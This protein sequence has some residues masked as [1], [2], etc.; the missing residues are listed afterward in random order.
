MA[1]LF[2]QSVGWNTQLTPQPAYSEFEQRS[3]RL[4]LAV[5]RM[6]PAR[7]PKSPPHASWRH[8]QPDDY[9]PSIKVIRNERIAAGPELPGAYLRF[10]HE[11]RSVPGKYVM[12]VVQRKGPLARGR[13]GEGEGNARQLDCESGGRVMVHTKAV[14]LEVE[15]SRLAHR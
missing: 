2:R 15:V 12:E 1:D 5:K 3:I 9:S 8:E 14:L 11:I 13:A 6:L 10:A 4:S 7:G